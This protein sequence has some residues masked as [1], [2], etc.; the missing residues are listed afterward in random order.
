MAGRSRKIKLTGGPW[1][2]Q[3]FSTKSTEDTTMVITVK[4]WYGRYDLITGQWVDLPARS[5]K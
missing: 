1:D 2:G 4:G 3:T 5:G